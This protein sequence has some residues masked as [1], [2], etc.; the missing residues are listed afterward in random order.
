MTEQCPSC[1]SAIT[2]A[3]CGTC[4]ERR[5]SAR[6]YSL[7]HFA[8]E[9][10]ETV[11][12]FDRSFL[13]TVRALVRRPG[14]LTA[15]YMRGERV[16]Y[17]RPLQLFLLVN[18]VY[19]LWAGWSGMHVFN[20]RLRDHLNSSPY[21]RQA[22]DLVRRRLP[23]SGM[24]EAQY[25]SAFDAKSLVLARTLVI[26]M[27]PMFAVALT[28]LSIR[29]RRP[30]V[31]HLV[32]SLHFFSILLLLTIATIPVI[33][34]EMVLW[35]AVAGPPSGWHVEDRAAGAT[36]AVAV[37]VYLV[38]AFRRAYGDGRIAALL[39]AFA[40]LVAIVAILT[41]YR[42]LLFYVTAYAI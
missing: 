14:E 13:H 9:A 10:L 6:Q 8:R 3:F 17:L 5:P 25:Q 32:F 40:S 38:F 11:T 27:V 1:G 20:T 37:M 28:V 31:Q 16:S 22:R 4:G 42:F 36:I 29:R 34:L 33:V 26:A 39:K 18:V 41:A 23:A 2:E 15:A 24:T 21:Q 7:A 30:V 35:R 19:F 12:D